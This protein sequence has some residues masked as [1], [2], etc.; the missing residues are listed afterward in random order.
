MSNSSLLKIASRYAEAL[1]ELS[2]DKDLASELAVLA[3]VLNKDTEI[4]QSIRHP[5]IKIEAKEKLLA[6][7]LSKKIKQESLGLLVLLVRRRRLDLLDFIPQLFLEAVNRKSGTASAELSSASELS[8]E[9]LTK[10]KNDLEKL[11]NKSIDISFKK[12]DSLIAGHKVNVSGTVIDSSLSSRL[13][14]MKQLLK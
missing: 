2:S 14:Q 13:K 5:Q 4:G 12:D 11:F 1:A 3:E 9:D 10:I 6:D 8:Q 7:S